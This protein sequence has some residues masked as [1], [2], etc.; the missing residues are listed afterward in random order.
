MI[1]GL[2]CPE[3]QVGRAGSVREDQYAG[4]R[5]IGCCLQKDV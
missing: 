3:K 2:Q 5:E 1:E 4:E